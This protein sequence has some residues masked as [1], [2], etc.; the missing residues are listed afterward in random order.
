M[1]RTSSFEVLNEVVLVLINGDK[2]NIKLVEYS[3]G[4][5]IIIINQKSDKK[6]ASNSESDKSS[7]E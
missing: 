1:V 5:L 7:G 3:H 2:H 6:T 4:Y